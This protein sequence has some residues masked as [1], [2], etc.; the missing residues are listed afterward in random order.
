MKEAS[1]LQRETSAE[2]SDA[3]PAKDEDAKDLS[4]SPPP[5]QGGVPIRQ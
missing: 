3:T 5:T 4:V 1:Y 2:E